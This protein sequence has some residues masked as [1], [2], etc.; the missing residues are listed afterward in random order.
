VTLHLIH[1]ASSH[2]G[3]SECV[4]IFIFLNPSNGSLAQNGKFKDKE[5]SKT[6]Y[7]IT[8]KQMELQVFQ[9]LEKNYKSNVNMVTGISNSDLHVLVIPLHL[10]PSVLLPNFRK[11]FHASCKNTKHVDYKVEPITFFKDNMMN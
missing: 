6:N 1:F 2:P 5:Q 4:S 7:T 3:T 9:V 10:M 8:R 11:Q